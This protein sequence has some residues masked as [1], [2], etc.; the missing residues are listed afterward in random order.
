MKTG[1]GTLFRPLFFFKTDFN[2]GIMTCGDM[3]D[4]FLLTCFHVT[5]GRGTYNCLFLCF[6]AILRLWIA[7]M[8]RHVFVDMLIML[9]WGMTF[10][11]PTF[12]VSK[13][14]FD[15]GMITCHDMFDMF[16]LICLSCDMGAWHCFSVYI[17][18]LK[19]DFDHTM[20]TCHNMFDMTGAGRLKMTCLSC[21]TGVWNFFQPTLT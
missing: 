4:M 18:V 3:F 2:R 7:G 21:D 17:F 12:F 20:M 5:W 14:D 19:P 9:Y 13:P 11:Q 6:Q 16:S 1:C 8:L 15:D 10:F